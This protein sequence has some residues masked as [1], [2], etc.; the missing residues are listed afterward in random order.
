MLLKYL[1]HARNS[2]E[3][4]LTEIVSEQPGGIGINPASGISGLYIKSLKMSGGPQGMNIRYEGSPAEIRVVRPHVRL[5]RVYDRG[6]WYNPPTQHLS[7]PLS[8][9]DP[10]AVAT[11]GFDYYRAFLTDA[12]ATFFP[13]AP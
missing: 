2:D 10:V 7:T 11:L 5:E 1:L 9:R 6:E 3:H 13:P 8:Q 12:E 4:T